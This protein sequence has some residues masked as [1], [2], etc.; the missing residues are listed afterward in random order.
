VPRIFGILSVVFGAVVGLFSGLA[1]MAGL[2]ATHQPGARR[3]PEDAPLIAMFLV[4][5]LWSALLIAVGVGQLRYRRWCLSATWVWCVSAIVVAVACIV[6]FVT[7][8]PQKEPAVGFAVMTAT[9][10]PYPALLLIFF[11][12]AAVKDSLED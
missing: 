10:L 6:G 11:S 5:A 4:L 8:V 1:A 3:G 7:V 12:R 2:I 9:L